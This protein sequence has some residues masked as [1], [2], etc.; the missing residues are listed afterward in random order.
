[1]HAIY[2][3]LQ[4]NL[5]TSEDMGKQYGSHKGVIKEKSFLKCLMLKLKLYS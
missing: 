4:E 1:M 5:Y 2:E 3:Q